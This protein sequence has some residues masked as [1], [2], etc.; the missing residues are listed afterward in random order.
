MSFPLNSSRRTY[1]SKALVSSGRNLY[2]SFSGLPL[3]T[4]AGETNYLPAP[5]SGKEEEEEQEEIIGATQDNSAVFAQ[6]PSGPSSYSYEQNGPSG[7]GGSGSGPS[8]INRPA[9]PVGDGNGAGSSAVPPC[10]A[11]LLLWAGTALVRH[12]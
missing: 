1:A 4:Q 8:N 12:V 3:T 10:L 11:F 6:P 7:V 2:C 5:T 9:Q